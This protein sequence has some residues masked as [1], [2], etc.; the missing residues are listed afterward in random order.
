MLDRVQAKALRLVA[1]V[2]IAAGVTGVST[3]DEIRR[4]APAAAA[5]QTVEYHYTGG[6]QHFTVPNGIYEL[7]LTVAGGAGANGQGTNGGGAGASG[8]KVT[9]T[10]PVTPGQVLNLWV[11]QGGANFGS[12]GRGDP[13]NDSWRGGDGGGFGGGASG[14]GGGGGAASHVY[15]NGMP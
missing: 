6:L 4:S 11:G 13:S 2:A 5:A 12:G 10:I 3:V 14:N 8:S 7:R 15:L 1:V 9:G